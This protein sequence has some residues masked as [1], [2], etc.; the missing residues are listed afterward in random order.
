MMIRVTVTLWEDVTPE[1]THL[2][3]DELLSLKSYLRRKRINSAEKV[4]GH[5]S[6]KKGN[7]FFQ[8]S[9]EIL[10]LERIH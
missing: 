1:T 2:V 7:Y 9:I 10:H 8:G 5:F 3:E 4:E 6:S